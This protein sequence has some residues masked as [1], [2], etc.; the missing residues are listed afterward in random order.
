MNASAATIVAPTRSRIWISLALAAMLI[1]SVF[2]TAVGIQSTSAQ[3][4]QAGLA[5]ATPADTVLFMSVNLDQ[6]TDQW[7]LTYSLLE[8]AGISALLESEAGA[9]A[10]DLGDVAESQGISGSGAI[11]FTDADS[12]VSYSSGDFSDAMDTTM[13]MDAADISEEVP[14]GFAFIVQPNDPDT[15]AAQFVTMAEDEAA[16]AGA[17]VETVDYNGVTGVVPAV[18]FDDVIDASTQ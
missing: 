3:E 1:V 11:V 10:E 8:R 18:W 4:S 13:T 2:S 6:S 7:G 16:A 12:L 9:S 17:T 14:E 15:L 5:S